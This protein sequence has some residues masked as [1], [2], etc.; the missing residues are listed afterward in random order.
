M[1]GTDVSVELLPDV[2]SALKEL[3]YNTFGKIVPGGYA[4]I[5]YP[6]DY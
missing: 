1:Y 5:K 3:G 4:Y 6:V 2:I